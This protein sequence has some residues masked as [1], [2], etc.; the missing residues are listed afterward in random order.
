MSPLGPEERR[1]A[2]E[3]QVERP[4]ESVEGSPVWGGEDTDDFEAAG[5]GGE[6]GGG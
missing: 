3:E 5:G 6:V 1:D 4:C 2:D